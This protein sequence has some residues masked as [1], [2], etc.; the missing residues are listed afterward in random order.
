MIEFAAWDQI[1]K[2]SIITWTESW[3]KRLLEQLMVLREE[4][5]TLLRVGYSDD[6]ANAQPKT[7]LQVSI[8]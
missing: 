6:R 3:N 2:P 5:D 4:R 1:D 7:S 8:R